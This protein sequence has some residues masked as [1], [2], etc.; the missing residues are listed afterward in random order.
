MRH[1]STQGKLVFLVMLPL[2][3]GFAGLGWLTQSTLRQVAVNGTLYTQIIADKDLLADI[4]PPPAYAIESWLTL[5]LVAWEVDP[6]VRSSLMM[7]CAQLD[8]QYD[9]RITHWAVE[10]KDPQMRVA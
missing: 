9:E 5:N 4:L 6:H 1:S 3:L 7:Q 10:L 8:A 2:L